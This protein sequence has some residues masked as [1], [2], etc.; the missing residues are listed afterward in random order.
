MPMI[1]GSVLLSGREA[2]RLL[3]IASPH[4]FC[5]TSTG[6]IQRTAGNSPIARHARARKPTPCKRSGRERTPC[7]NEL[8]KPPRAH[9]QKIWEGKFPLQAREFHVFSSG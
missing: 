3:L 5:S 8:R 6:R 1:S 4:V 2:S 9:E 7:P